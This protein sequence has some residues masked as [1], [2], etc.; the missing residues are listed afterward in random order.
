MGVFYLYY[1]NTFF[2]ISLKNKSSSALG[3]ALYISKKYKDVLVKYVEYEETSH[4]PY[5]A[6]TDSVHWQKGTSLQSY[7]TCADCQMTLQ[8]P[9]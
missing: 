8:R 7:S 5:L 4:T 9:D 6:N 2:C 1:F 3:Y